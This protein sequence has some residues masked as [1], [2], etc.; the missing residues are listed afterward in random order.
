MFSCLPPYPPGIKR[1]KRGFSTIGLGRLTS[2][3]GGWG[4]W[5]ERGL[6][7]ASYFWHKTDRIIGFQG[8][9]KK[10]IFCFGGWGCHDLF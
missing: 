7:E 10:R 1:K 4:G 6:R 2:S 9:L 8:R 5:G 3:N